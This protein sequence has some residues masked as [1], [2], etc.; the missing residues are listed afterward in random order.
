[1]YPCN[2]NTPIDFKTKSAAISR[3]FALRAPKAPA[4]SKIF[5]SVHLKVL[6]F[7]GVCAL[8]T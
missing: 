2:I 1:M 5:V 8:C 3:I 7:P 4:N 6:Q